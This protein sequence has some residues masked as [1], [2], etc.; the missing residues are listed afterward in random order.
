MPQD[1][2]LFAEMTRDNL[3]LTLEA[4]ADAELW[5]MLHVAVIDD[6]PVALLDGLNT[7]S[8]RMTSDFRVESAGA[9]HWV[10]PISLLCMGSCW[11]TSEGLDHESAFGGRMAGQ[12]SECVTGSV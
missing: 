11:R 5:A 3:L 8:V 10:A 12:E 6:R 2:V 4:V 1:A 7:G 9:S